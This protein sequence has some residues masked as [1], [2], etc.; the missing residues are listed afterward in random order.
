MKNIL[1]AL[2]ALLAIAGCSASPTAPPA[3]KPTIPVPAAVPDNAYAKLGGSNKWTNNAA[4]TISKPKAF[5]PDAYAAGFT[6]G[7]TAL[8]F[9]VTIINGTNTIIDSNMA[10]VDLVANDKTSEIIFDDKHGMPNS[11]VLPGKS[12]VFKVG[13]SVPPGTKELV[14]TASPGFEYQ[15]KHWTN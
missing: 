15:N 9:T 14:V 6:K 10:T 4:M 2:F 8:E 7:H 3:P 5:V 13:F 1:I 12:F 11:S